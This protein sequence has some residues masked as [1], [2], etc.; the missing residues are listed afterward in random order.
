MHQA[1]QRECRLLDIS[2]LHLLITGG[3]EQREE[4]I[5]SFI[6]LSH[7]LLLVVLQSYLHLLVHTSGGNGVT[8]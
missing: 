3:V 6:N 4:I 2:K 5:E 7:L 1:H 8:K